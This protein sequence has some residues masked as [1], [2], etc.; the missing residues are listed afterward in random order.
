M[1]LVFLEKNLAQTQLCSVD[2]NI[3][4]SI[5]TR[6]PANK[7][8]PTTSIEAHKRVLPLRRLS[9]QEFR[10]LP[11]KS[12][13]P[14]ELAMIEWKGIVSQAYFHSRHL[15]EGKDKLGVM[16]KRFMRRRHALPL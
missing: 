3:Y 16:A 8:V 6:K 14:E 15:G 2:G 11:G 10:R 4:Y 13:A 1:D 12:K 9:H 7:I 5:V